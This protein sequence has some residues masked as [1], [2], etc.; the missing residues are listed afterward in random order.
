MVLNEPKCLD[1]WEFHPT[2]CS[3]W[4]SQGPILGRLAIDAPLEIQLFSPLELVA[5]QME[6]WVVQ[7]RCVIEESVALGSV[8]RRVSHLLLFAAEIQKVPALRLLIPNPPRQVSH[9][10][11][12]H[13]SC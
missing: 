3:D 7:P 10:Q 12:A 2:A 5:R 6:F 9:Q 4:R 13:R 1:W 8:T 11:A